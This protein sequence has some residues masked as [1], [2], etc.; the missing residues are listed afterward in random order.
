MS[1][2]QKEPSLEVKLRLAEKR[3]GNTRW[4]L[5]GA[6]SLRNPPTAERAKHLREK[7]AREQALVAELR[8]KRDAARAEAAS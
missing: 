3:A 4:A 8:A 1:R 6:G 7:L 5:T 2:K